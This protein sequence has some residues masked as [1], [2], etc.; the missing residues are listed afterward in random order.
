[1]S[2][3][4]M[5][6]PATALVLNRPAMSLLVDLASF[7]EELWVALVADGKHESDSFPVVGYVRLQKRLTQHPPLT[8]YAVVE[9]RHA[10]DP[11]PNP[12][13]LMTIFQWPLLADCERLGKEGSARF[14]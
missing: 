2:F 13:S 14:G 10:S 3:F 6:M 12:A 1:M 7:E 11:P 8:T 5:R 4:P 9:A